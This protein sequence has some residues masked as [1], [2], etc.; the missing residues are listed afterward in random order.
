M[1][2]FKNVLARIG[3]GG[4]RIDTVIDE[5]VVT[6][7]SQIKGEV[8]IQ[9]GTVHQQIKE[10]FLVLNTKV[11]K[12]SDDTKYH[13]TLPVQRVHIPLAF[14]IQPGEKKSIPFA[15]DIP[16]HSPISFGK[17]RLW[18][19][20][21]AE[22]PSAIDA[23]DNDNLKILPHPAQQKV[24]DA[25]EEL[26]FRLRNSDNEH[27]PGTELGFEQELEYDSPLESNQQSDGLKVVFTLS[28][29]KLLVRF[30][31][32]QQSEIEFSVLDLTEQATDFAV[33]AIRK[34]MQMDGRLH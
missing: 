19:Q 4:T 7:G 31:N 6:V 12:Q 25:L 2:F 26:G 15:L 21:E 32:E 8:L 17:V 22:I 14:D 23:Q 29:Q 28:E 16:L 9:G 18:I 27:R 5:P 13:V 34:K 1:G 11:E 10:I 3:I 20:T 24:L 33:D 30:L